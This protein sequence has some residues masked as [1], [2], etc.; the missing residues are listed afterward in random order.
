MKIGPI[1]PDFLFR[2]L[3]GSRQSGPN[4]EGAKVT[5]QVSETVKF[6]EKGMPLAQ[7]RED[8]AH[9]RH[10]DMKWNDPRNMRTAFFGGDDVAAL[11]SEVYDQFQGD[12]LLYGKFIFPSLL[13]MSQELSSMSLD[14]LGG[15]GNSSAHF[16]V[17]GTESNILGTKTGRD[18][19]AAERPVPG[20][21]E[22]LMGHTCHAGLNKAC[23]LLGLKPVRLPPNLT[24]LIDVDEMRAH[25]NE[26]TIML[27]G[28]APAYPL[29]SI[30]PIE[31]IAALA[32]EHNL[33]L[34]VDGCVGGFLLP[35][36]KDIDD[37]PPFDLSVDGVCSMS[38]DL[39]K[40][41]FASNGASMILLKNKEHDKYLEF[42]FDEWPIEKFVTMS[43]GGTKPGGA[44]AAAWAVMRYLGKEGYRDRAR[45][46]VETRRAIVKQVEQ[47]DALQMLGKPAAGFAAFCGKPGTDMPAIRQGMVDKGWKFASLVDPVGINLLLNVSHEA[48]VDDFCKDLKQAVA[49]AK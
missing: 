35:F 31:D 41:G 12:N 24:G 38:A 19:A 4:L 48:V 33:W 1:W 21:P 44:A 7:L 10:N 46:I 3:G 11:A 45:R 49:D 2:A 28:S 39:H 18:W 13:K 27:V 14:I 30:D 6:P 25:I 23:D 36:V 5:T 40:Y 37:V 16:T 17:G 9:G 34:H 32:K 15:T 42:Y 43:I 29:G 20:K 26:N 47:I 22:V 8:I